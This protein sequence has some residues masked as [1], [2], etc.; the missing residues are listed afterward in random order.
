MSRELLGLG[1]A[2]PD[3]DNV[4]D[5]PLAKGADRLRV[6]Q[7]VRADSFSW[8][9]YFHTPQWRS[10]P[11]LSEAPLASGQSDIGQRLPFQPPSR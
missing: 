3:L 11:T 2:A 5:G 4:G 8:P 6:V 9:S 7:P 1:K 10:H